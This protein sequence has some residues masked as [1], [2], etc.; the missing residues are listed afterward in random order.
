[1]CFS[2]IS[3][4]FSDSVDETSVK[5]I[6]IH[7]RGRRWT[8]GIEC[9]GVQVDSQITRYSKLDDKCVR[10]SN[11]G[12]E[13][14]QTGCISDFAFAEVARLLKTP[15]IELELFA[16]DV[17]PFIQGEP[18]ESYFNA[19]EKTFN[20]ENVT[21]VNAKRVRLIGLT[22]SEMEAVLKWVSVENLVVIRV[23]SGKNSIDERG[24]IVI[25]NVSFTIIP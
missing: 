11:S 23:Y 6:R 5:K 12:R 13:T 20:L 9:I 15:E 16:V 14:T 7:W 8:R 3:D 10:K 2:V 17:P 18:R 19:M 1:M 24:A 22:I 4:Q 21:R 25:Q